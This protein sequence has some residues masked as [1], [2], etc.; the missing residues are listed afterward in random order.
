MCRG[1]SWMCYPVSVLWRADSCNAGKFMPYP[2]VSGKWWLFWKIVFWSWGFALSNSVFVKCASVVVSMEI[3]GIT[4]D[5]VYIYKT[6]KHINRTPIYIYQFCI[7]I[8]ESPRL[9]KTSKIIQF[10]SPPITNITMSL[11]ATSEHFLNTSRDSVSST[12]LGS[13]FQ[14]LNTLL[15]KN[16]FL[17]SSLNLPWHNLMP[18]C[19]D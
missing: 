16:L 8:T 14:C 5:V 18:F 12:S 11:S 10:N 4:F 2:T 3:G 19:Q 13:P 15:E 9:E 17:T 7:R 1:R 6:H